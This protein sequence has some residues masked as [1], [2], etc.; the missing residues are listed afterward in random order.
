MVCAALEKFFFVIPVH[1]CRKDGHLHSY[2]GE[3]VVGV[4]VGDLVGF[5]VGLGEGFLV[6][7]L[8]GLGEGFLVGRLVGDLVGLGEIGRAHV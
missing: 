7:F 4:A 8:V 2:S 1:W 5:L 6:G 3:P